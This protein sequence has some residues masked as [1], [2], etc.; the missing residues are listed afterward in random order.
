[1]ARVFRLTMTF[2]TST[3][4]VLLKADAHTLPVDKQPGLQRSSV[5]ARLPGCLSDSTQLCLAEG[6][7][8]S[9]LVPSNQL[10]QE[11]AICFLIFSVPEYKWCKSH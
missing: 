10:P 7:T 11:T 4:K 3:W 5:W 9:G 1:M 6:Y 2:L 8:K